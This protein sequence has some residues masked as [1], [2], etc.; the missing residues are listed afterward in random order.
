MNLKLY[1]TMTRS[2]ENFQPIE[3]GKVRLYTCGPTVYNYAHIGNLRTYV[4][5]D[6]LKRA[7]VHLGG[8]EVNHVMNVTDV[9]H[10]TDDAD[11]GEDKMEKGA[12]REGKSVE[13]IAKH[14]WQAFDK[15]LEDL[16]I[17]KPTTW[18][19]A[20]DEIDTQKTQVETLM[21]KGYTYTIED[22]I[23]FDTSKLDDYGKLARLDVEGLQ[24]G[25]RVEMAA[26]KKQPTDFALWKFSP[27]DKQRLM[28]WDNP[29]GIEGK[30]FPGWH[31]ECSA[32]AIKHLGERLDIHCGG[33][34]HVN[35]H[36]SNEIAQAEAALGHEWCNWWMHGEFLT[37]GDAGKMAKSSGEFLTLRVLMDRLGEKGL[38][39]ADAAG[40]YRYFLL[41]AHYRQQL[42]FSWEALDAAASA[43]KN[44]K[45]IVLELRKSYTGQETP[46][47]IRMQPFNEAVANDLNM[48]RALAAMW[49]VAK[50]TADAPAGEIYATL[51]EMDKVLGL[52]MAEMQEKRISKEE[53]EKIFSIIAERRRAKKDKD[54]RLADECREKAETQFNATISDAQFGVKVELSSGATIEFTNEELDQEGSSES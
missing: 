17:L 2:V 18:C 42:A 3:P 25:A 13:D 10:L 7:L 22:G 11:A 51:L 39:D 15:D 37:M 6:V 48:P 53:M 41:G 5:E 12:A 9:G 31:I 14:Y 46:F 52:G 1:N 19:W 8:Y 20:T 24:A 54:F 16:N 45:R 36:H 49:A 32:M 27:K 30:G 47:E 44:L 28:E 21:E 43:Y 34:D 50:D 4:F 26:G 29:A 33:V 38:S 35:V 23:Y 40:A